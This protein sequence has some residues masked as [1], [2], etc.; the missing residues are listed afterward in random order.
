MPLI[1]S[2]V[3][4]VYPLLTP[5]RSCREEDHPPSLSLSRSLLLPFRIGARRGKITPIP[6]LTAAER[7]W[8][9]AYVTPIANAYLK[10]PQSA[11]PSPHR[12]NTHTQK[13]LGYLYTGTLSPSPFINGL[14]TH[15][16]GVDHR[17]RGEGSTNLSLSLRP[18]ISSVTIRCCAV[19]CCFLYEPKP[20]TQMHI[21]HSFDPLG[22][23]KRK[24]VANSVPD[25]KRN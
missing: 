1:I 10:P 24:M 2:F 12:N 15:R 22:W 8:G 25:A 19:A 7:Q 3:D 4:T 18:G 20:H 23:Q 14:M 6:R 9:L 13:H 16:M 5:F 11:H 17:E 21:G